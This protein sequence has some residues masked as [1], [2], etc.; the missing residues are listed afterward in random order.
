MSE[1][2]KAEADS[3][4]AYKLI[5]QLEQAARNDPDRVAEALGDVIE[6]E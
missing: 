4:E 6:T 3:L 1:E 5:D 2:A